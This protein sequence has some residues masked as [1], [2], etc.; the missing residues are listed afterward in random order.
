MT[1]NDKG[2]KFNP[3]IMYSSDEKFRMN[4]SE[5]NWKTL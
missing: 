3:F 5:D 4:D 1:F 2:K